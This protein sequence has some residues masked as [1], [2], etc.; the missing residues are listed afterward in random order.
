MIFTKVGNGSR[1]F[2]WEDNWLQGGPL[3]IKTTRENLLNS[4]IL[5]DQKLD[6]LYHDAQ[7]HFSQSVVY[8]FPDI[9]GIPPLS[10]TDDMFVWLPS[11]SGSFSLSH[12]IRWLSTHSFPKPWHHLIWSPFSIP[13]CKFSLWLA[14]QGR[15]PTLDRSS[16]RSF[17]CS[18]V[19][20]LCNM[21]D[22]T[23]NHLF[24][25]CSYTRPIWISLQHKCGL[26]IAPS[27]WT[28]L[29]EWITNRWPRG[30]LR[31]SV[32]KLVLSMAVNRIWQE[33]NN[34]IFTSQRCSQIAIF[35]QITNMVRQKL[36]SIKVKDSPIARRLMLDWDLLAF[37]RSPPEP[38]DLT[39]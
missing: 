38:P 20:K 32:N 1:T 6:S 24:F 9:V 19:C 4:P 29:V 25:A 33:R 12:T 37:I 18:R 30:D 28:D 2:F 5:P 8:L 7:W 14:V 23:H 27:S 15:L 17:T 36:L 3:S 10:T 16:M 39:P 31:S 26:H 21:V 35:R 34:R 11:P 22:E 13:R